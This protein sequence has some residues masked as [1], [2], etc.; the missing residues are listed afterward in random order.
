MSDE[1][2]E[3]GPRNGQGEEQIKA[4]IQ[5]AVSVAMASRREQLTRRSEEAHV[6]PGQL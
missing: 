3:V 1:D 5:E 4:M 6:T 2:V